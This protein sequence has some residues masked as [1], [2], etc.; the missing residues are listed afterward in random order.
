MRNLDSIL[1]SG[2]IFLLTMSH[3][4]KAMIFP[5][6]MYRCESRTLTKEGC[7]VVSCLV[8]SNSL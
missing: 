8:V 6:V 5:V 4:V 7:A 3:L 2:D 1:K